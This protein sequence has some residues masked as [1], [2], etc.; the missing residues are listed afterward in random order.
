ME[1]RCPSC[2]CASPGR[3]CANCGEA[4]PGRALPG[5][6]G[7]V[8]RLRRS[9]DALASPPGR[10][11]R[12]WIDGRRVGYVAPVPLFL[13]TNVAFF[14]VQWASG[15]S[16]LSWPLHIHLANDILGVVKPL[17]AWYP[18]AHVLADPRTV[19]VF[20]ALEVVHAKALV[21]VMLPLFALPLLAVPLA[22]RREFSG[23]FAFA[24]HFYTFALIAL[25]A[26]FPLVSLA[27]RG[28]AAAGLRATPDAIDVVV[29]TLQGLM[30]GGYLY[31]ALATLTP[32]SAL[33][34]IVYSLALLYALWLVLLGYHVVVFA[35]TLASL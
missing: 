9:L 11:T 18:G 2:G 16:V 32:L 12:D 24:A 8:A 35:A 10:L 21:I 27:L 3:Y 15:V 5:A 14:L 7:F 13:Y 26:L 19:A 34:R 20:D 1:W 6:R 31:R 17:A 29:T 25:C 23:A 4:E 33:R 28:L 22:G 30:L